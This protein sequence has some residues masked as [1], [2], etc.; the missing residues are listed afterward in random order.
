MTNSRT[1]LTI[2]TPEEAAQMFAEGVRLASE[3]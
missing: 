3:G 2:N 1:T